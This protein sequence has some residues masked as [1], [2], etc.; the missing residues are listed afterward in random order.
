MIYDFQ[1]EIKQIQNL[2]Y[3]YLKLILLSALSFIFLKKKNKRIP[4]L[5]G[6]GHS[7]F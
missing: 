5:S 3:F 4:L 2:F 6:L 7:G 1:L